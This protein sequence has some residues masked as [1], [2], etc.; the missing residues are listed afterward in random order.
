MAQAVRAHSPQLSQ[1]LDRTFLEHMETQQQGLQE[2][3]ASQ[4]RLRVIFDKLTAPP[5]YPAVF[6]CVVTT[7]QGPR[8]LVT[9]GGTRM[10]VGAAEGVD[11]AA[12][13]PGELVFLGNER[14]VIMCQAGQGVPRWG[15]VGIFDSWVDERWMVL[16]AREDKVT[17]E[18]AAAV[19]KAGLRSGD[20]VRWTREDGMAFEKVPRPKES[21]F[22]LE[23]TPKVTFDQV[24]GLGPQILE[25]QRVFLL[26]QDYAEVAG[27]YGQAPAR[28][29]LLV[30]SP[31]GGKTMMARA[32]ANWLAKRQPSGR[33]LFMNVKPSSLHSMWYSQSEANYREVFRVARE[34]G[35]S[36]P[37]VPVIL[38]F[39]EIDS[40]GAARGSVLRVDN[41]VVTAFAAELDG[42][43]DRGNI[44]VLAATNRAD[45]LDEALVRPGRLGDKIITVPRPNMDAARD[46][47][48]KYLRSTMPYGSGNGHPV[49]PEEARQ[50]IIDA[51]VSHI[52]VPNGQ[53][54]LA[55]LVCR[56]GKRRAV[57]GRDLISGAVIAKVV[58]AAAEHACLRE[59]E[60]G[61]PGIL[62]KD[63]L[64][65]ITDEFQTQISSLTPFNCHRRLTELPRDV[66]VVAVEPVARKVTQPHRYIRLEVA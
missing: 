7:P 35:G 36:Q 39:D 4:K 24:G 66:D 2:A 34:A 63:V 37:G 59:I 41:S 19:R 57:H 44:L 29:V 6:H 13:E 10:T 23:D 33:C 53:G 38:F 43:E 45:A 54:E 1:Q 58:S 5:W 47:F 3:E 61:R 27:K 30:G 17:V 9:C 62:L 31:G 28:A 14:S 50:T 46:I 56:D 48:R 25:M 16:R 49:D 51:A 11:L 40:S 32:L 21:A 22:F 15:E 65:A 52:Y 42:L 60:T 18:A 64:S 12:L 20:Q 26:H 8:A 55:A